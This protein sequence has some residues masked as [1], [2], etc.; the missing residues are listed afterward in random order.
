MSDQPTPRFTPPPPSPPPCAGYNEK[1]DIWALGILI[2]ELIA[3]RPPFEVEDPDQTAL[4]IMHA[5]LEQFP[6]YMSP[7]CTS[8]IKLVSPASFKTEPPEIESGRE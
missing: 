2:Y 6:G 5:D 3:G 7:Q 4:L 1:V 8:F